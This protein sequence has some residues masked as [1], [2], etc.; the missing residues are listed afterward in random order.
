M[1]I[2]LLALVVRLLGSKGRHWLAEA[3][4]ATAHAMARLYLSGAGDIWGPLSQEEW[5]HSVAI[6]PIAH[7]LPPLDRP[8]G[9]DFAPGF[10]RLLCWRIWVGPPFH[11]LP[12]DRQLAIA[13][14]FEIRQAAFYRHMARLS[15]GPMRERYAAIAQEEAGHASA[16]PPPCQRCLRREGWAIAAMIFWDVPRILSGRFTY[17]LSK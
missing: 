9:P 17:F 16:F 2:Y 6:R 14:Y 4:S 13:A 15:R 5:E 1:W 7:K 11:Q 8:Q 10:S 12:H 3:E